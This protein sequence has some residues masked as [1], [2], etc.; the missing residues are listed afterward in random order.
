MLQSI[1]ELRSTTGCEA[2]TV[3]PELHLAALAQHEMQRLAVR[4]HVLVVVPQTALTPLVKAGEIA[5]LAGLA[6][7]GAF[8]AVAR[9]PLQTVPT[10]QRPVGQI[11]AAHNLLHLAALRLAELDPLVVLQVVR[12]H[13][14]EEMVRHDLLALVRLC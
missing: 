6:V 11:D 2:R 7:V 3:A 12:G 13:K 1:V 10:L 5:R 9:L 4:R 14:R 8:D